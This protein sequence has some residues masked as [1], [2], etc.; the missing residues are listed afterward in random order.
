MGEGRKKRQCLPA[1]RIERKEE[2]ESTSGWRPLWI[3]FRNRDQQ[4]HVVPPF[5]RGLL[6]VKQV[7]F[8]RCVSQRLSHSITISRFVHPPH[9]RFKQELRP[10]YREPMGRDERTNSARTFVLG[11]IDFT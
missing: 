3:T 11:R 8:L 1:L 5:D 9:V 7:D 6:R 10:R 2:D 4:I